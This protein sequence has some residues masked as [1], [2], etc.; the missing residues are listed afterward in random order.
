MDAIGEVKLL[1]GNYNAE[2][3]ARNGGQMNITIKNGTGSVS[4]Q[5]LLLLPARGIQCQRVV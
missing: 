2:Y 3:G 4:R 1:T 5:R